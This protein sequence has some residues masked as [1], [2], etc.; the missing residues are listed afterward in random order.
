MRAEGFVM[1]NRIN[2]DLAVSR[3]LGDFVYKDDSK[4]D[5]NDQAVSCE[6]DITILDRSDEDNYLLFA[7]DG[8]WDVFQPEDMA[9]V[10]KECLQSY[11]KVVEALGRFLDIC[12]DKGSKDIMTVLLVLL[13]QMYE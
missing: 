9:P 11:E 1:N 4:E 10:M 6:P 2:G 5:P 8:I 12:L 7:C 3:T 13:K